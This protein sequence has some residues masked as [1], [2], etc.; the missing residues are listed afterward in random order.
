MSD[1][2][3]LP[4]LRDPLRRA[5]VTLPRWL[6]RAALRVMPVPRDPEVRVRVVTVGPRRLRIYLPA[7]RGTGPGLLW[8]HGGG[9]LF[10]AAKQ[11]E[12]L[13]LSTAKRLGIVIVSVDYRL[14][15]EH[16]FPA[17]HDDVLAAWHWFQAHADELHVD[18]SRIAIGG[19][20]A[21]AGLAA[22]VVQRIH[23]DGGTQPVAQWLF[24]PMLDDRTAADRSLD[25]GRHAVW[26]NEKNR[27]GWRG[28]LGAQ[29]GTVTPPRYAAPA[30]AGDLAG[31]PA[32]FLTWTD[33]ELFAAE[34]RAYADALEAA[35]VPVD[36]DLVVGGA[37]GF[38]NWAKHTPVAQALI[39]RAQEWLAAAVR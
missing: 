31:L 14:A 32:A 33:T 16:P 10:G 5:D 1:E 6:I 8:V 35:G 4:E 23:D 20:S 28:Y 13:C 22:G 27:V 34:N 26:N 19:E 11:D 38:E 15:P 36:V 9:L 29:P 2:A 21:G 24:A 37:H 7:R 12:S 25:A 18:P 17:A 30:R 3:I 39:G